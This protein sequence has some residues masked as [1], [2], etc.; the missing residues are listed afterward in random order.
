MIR[1][2]VVD[3]NLVVRSGLGTLLRAGNIEVAGEAADGRRAID[4]AG[5]LKPDIVLLDV[6][7]PVL[8]GVEAAAPLSKVS[9]VLMLSY[10][11]D[12]AVIAAAIRNGA[13][14]YL[15][16]GTF[17]DIELLQAV[18]ETVAG[19]Q[20]PLSPQ[21]ALAVVEALQQ[22]TQGRRQERRGMPS[23]SPRETEVMELVARGQANGE[24]ARTLAI[25]EFTVKNHINRIF[26]RLGVP[27]RGAAIAYW[28]GT[29][30]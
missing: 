14:G 4:L 20:S 2:L 27:S 18:R 7:M 3:D 11:H 6:C 25:S 23:L 12:S 21:A 1:A 19:R 29:A 30:E 26:A 13:S 9:K 10:H 8:G 5:R 22:T 17:D 16:H 15:V 28:L 24:V